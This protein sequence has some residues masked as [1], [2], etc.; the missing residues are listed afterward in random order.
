[1]GGSGDQRWM[2]ETPTGSGSNPDSGEALRRYRG[3][4]RW[5]TDLLRSQVR[6]R[7]LD[8]IA[9]KKAYL[10]RHSDGRQLGFASP[11]LQELLPTPNVG[12]MPLV[13]WPYLV[14]HHEEAVELLL[15]E[16]HRLT[17]RIQSLTELGV[18]IPLEKLELLYR[19]SKM[20]AS[21]SRS[22]RTHAS[23]TSTESSQDAAISP[24]KERRMSW[25]STWGSPVLRCGGFHDITTLSP[26]YFT[27]CAPRI[28]PSSAFATEALQIYSFEIFELDDS[29]KWP[30][31]I[32]GVVAARDAVDGNRN[33]LFSRSRANC[34]LL[35]KEDPFLHL[36][37][38]SRA[39][40]SE[41]PVDFEVE[42]RIK[43]GSESQDKALISS[44]NH[45]HFCADTA[46]FLGCLCSAKLNLQ[47]VASAVQATI[48]SVRVTG[49]LST[50]E[51]GG[52]IVC[53]LSTAGRQVVL[54]DSSEEFCEDLE[55]YVPLA[56]NVVTVESKGSLRII[57]KSY[58]ESHLVAHQA[59]FEFD[60][61][62]CQISSQERVIGDSKL[63][64]VI[65]WS[66]LVRDKLDNMAAGYAFTYPSLC[67]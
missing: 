54:F 64:V 60:A 3:F 22:I 12:S 10:E 41:Y 1:M 45:H 47:T 24:Y 44:T 43:D 31:N 18:P 42:L 14:P 33:L 39:I 26:M 57:I 4:L 30:L 19:L 48:L 29:L 38:P 21:L 52:Q 34:Q 32:Y 66:L 16:A 40:L 2:Q 13:S 7:G 37:G 53:S 67:G 28:I 49:G 58:T 55:G 25:V 6:S 8:T 46:L 59:E 36:T 27:P 11:R 15:H 5:E 62:H 35:T 50:F 61:K 51:F 23:P 56:R 65:A 9:G 17:Y 63:Q 20:C